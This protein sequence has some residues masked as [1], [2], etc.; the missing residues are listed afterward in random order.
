[1]DHRKVERA[2]YHNGIRSFQSF[3]QSETQKFGFVR[4][5]FC[6]ETEFSSEVD[7]SKFFNF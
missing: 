5:L 2:A 7:H 1:M 3:G 6:P 4:S